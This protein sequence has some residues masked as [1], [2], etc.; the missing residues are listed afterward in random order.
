[1]Q[2]VSMDGGRAKGAVGVDGKGD[3]RVMVCL[4]RGFMGW[5][6]KGDGVGDEGLDGVGD[7]G[8]YGWDWGGLVVEEALGDFLGEELVGFFGGVDAV[9]E[10]G[11][12]GFTVDDGIVGQIHELDAVVVADGLLQGENIL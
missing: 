9:G 1:M 5:V 3:G 6:M 2:W 10:V 12:D 7:K 8:L 11:A 4:M